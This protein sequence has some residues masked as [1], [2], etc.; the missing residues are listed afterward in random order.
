MVLK[1]LLN[2]GDEVLTFAPFFGEYR[3]YVGNYDGV[4]K[5]VPANTETFQPN[6]EVF[7]EMITEKT[8]AVIVNSPNNPSGVIYS[9]ETIKELAAILCEKEKLCI[10]NVSGLF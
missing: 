5:V 4:L 9:E 10:K 2:P 1:T 7:G 6:L 8:K 3:S